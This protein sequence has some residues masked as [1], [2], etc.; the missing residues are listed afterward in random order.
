MI[1][2][3]GSGDKF[4]IIII[5]ICLPRNVNFYYECKIF[6][7]RIT[8]THTGDTGNNLLEW[9][10]FLVGNDWKFPHI[11]VIV[12]TAPAQPYTPL[13]GQVI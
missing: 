6:F 9:I 7:F 11:K 1:F 8:H 10:R 12:P 13:D 3:H 5:R 4:V 2:L